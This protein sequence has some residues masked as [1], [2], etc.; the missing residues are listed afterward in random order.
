MNEELNKDLS[1]IEAE[2]Q[3]LKAEIQRLQG[4][5][6]TAGI[7]YAF[8]EPLE[9]AEDQAESRECIINENILIEQ[10]DLFITLFH[11]RTDV[12]AKRFISKA[13][14]VGY[15]PG[16]NNFWRQGL[17]PKKEGQKIKCLDCPNRNFI[18]LNRRLLREHLEGHK[19]DGTDVI[20]IYPMLA[21]E[22]CYF[23]VFDFDNHDKK[24][25]TNEDEGANQNND[26]IE[27]INAMREIC[28]TNNID[29]LVERSRSGKGAHVWLFFE[30]AIPVFLARKFGMA[31][32]TKGAESVNQTNFKSY[33]RMLPAQD[34]MPVG[35]LG[36]L[37]A[38]PLQ[39]QA[40]RSG[41]SAF[42]DEEW[43]VISD[44]WQLMRSI[45]KNSEQFVEEKVKDWTSEGVLGILA[46]DMSEEGE[47]DTLD[48]SVKPWEKKNKIQIAGEDIAGAVNIVIANQIFI[49][50]Q[51]VK[52]RT[53]NRFRRLAAFSNPEFYK[54]QAMGFSTK[55]I[56][57]IIQCGSDTLDYICLPRG[58]EDKLLALLKESDIPYYITE[59]RQK[60]QSIQ[61]EF[62]GKLYQEQEKAA[63]RMLQY[64]YG[65]L[66]AA[67]G[68]GKTV[69]GAYLIAKC[70]VNALVL[71]HNREIMKNWMNDF[72]TF[73]KIEE[74]LPTYETKK[75]KR[76]RKSLIGTLY[77]G[78]D[79]L[80]QIIDVAM[81]TSFGKQDS[82]DQ[83][84]KD[85]G[86]VIVDECHHSGA[87]T[88]E[89]VIREIQAEHVYGLTAT[90]KREDGKEQK[91]FMQFGPIRYRL[92]AKDRAKMQNFEHYVYPRF[93]S[94]V[95]SSGV[96]WNINTAYKELIGNVR[97][98][99]QIVDDV[100]ECVKNGRT[101]VILTKFTEHAQTLR[102][103]LEDKVRYVFLLQGGKSNKERDRITNELRNVPEN[104][105]VVLVAI[106]QYIGE[107][108]NFPRLDTMMLAAPISW[109]G[110]VEQYAG[111][112]H[113]DY[114]G[115]KDVIIYDYVDIQIKVLERMYHKRLRTYK[116]IG[117]EIC[118]NLFHE[119][120]KENAIFDMGSYQ[121]IYEKDL[122]QANKEIVIS[123]PE[124]NKVMVKRTLELIKIGQISGVMVNVIT[125]PAKD[126]PENR[127]EVT[128]QLIEEL[129]QS[130][131]NVRLISGLHEHF[132]VIDQEVVWYGSLNLLSKGKEQDNLM[133]VQ[134]PEIASELLELEFA[135]KAGATHV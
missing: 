54:N 30:E 53:L 57:R 42:I 25:E 76:T 59:K 82:I 44:P 118:L 5:L 38:L 2:N 47:K 43:K 111:R 106:G 122:Q 60:G 40:L 1:L 128:G 6:E 12:Y 68:F 123:S 101:P 92:T 32:L 58:C 83:R 41:N 73:L 133:R 130:G 19:I 48:E 98:N 69:I 117:Y 39:R 112:L 34:K 29:A 20:G 94:L 27:D 55:G 11:G 115:K 105:S 135:E 96:T 127:M 134:S 28:R 110:N 119:R 125:I 63:E 61:V 26:W 67:T 75:G 132:A 88:H 10:I 72:Q 9:K 121:A 77:A 107:G 62:M 14:N 109:Q 114:E 56:P 80:G 51:N 126:Y 37:I 3:S 78:H 31:L 100:L 33:D 18:K 52:A 23:I 81:I 50:K 49:E 66:G 21:D 104:E 95:N 4:L 86:L 89:A 116:K 129:I 16:C 15:S 97:R 85:Y 91:V 7:K 22:T 35:G 45:K 84:I 87:Q 131:V 64:E 102:K 90:P 124:I 103:M 108:F 79:S 120:Q 93:T 74:P 46:S 17:C 113:R 65:I 13:G 70:K 36:N 24:K 8:C 99:R 71:V